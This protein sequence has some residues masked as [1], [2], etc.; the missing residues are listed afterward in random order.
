MTRKIL[1]VLKERILFIDGAM[2]T[3]IHARDLDL[4]RD[5]S[6]L[7]NCCEII[8]VNRPDVVRDIHASFLEV[9]WDAPRLGR[10]RAR[11]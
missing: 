2:G 6:G 4:D 3:S 11:G 9:G 7:E 5:Y 8:N 10:L 1:E